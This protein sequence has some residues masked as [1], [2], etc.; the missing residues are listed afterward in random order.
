MADIRRTLFLIVVNFLCFT[1]AY[2]QSTLPSSGGNAS[3][4]EGS[5]TYT[6]GQVV[7]NTFLAADGCVAQG[8]Q[9]PYE[10]SVVTAIE[11]KKNLVAEYEVFPN[12]TNGKI[13]LIAKPFDNE[14]LRFSLFELN[15][16]EH[17]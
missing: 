10:N 17:T 2:G 6:I 8:V 13:S 3:G 9:Q 4:G 7:Y 16:I 1:L 5:V 14:N 15:Q 11:H 12:P